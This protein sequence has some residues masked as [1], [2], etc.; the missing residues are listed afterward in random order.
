MKTQKLYQDTVTIFDKTLISEQIPVYRPL[1]R[2]LTKILIHLSSVFH[3]SRKH[4][5]I[6]KNEIVS[7]STPET[8][9]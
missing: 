2:T 5:I 8:M 4:R 6:E 7:P 3:I 1:T 9:M